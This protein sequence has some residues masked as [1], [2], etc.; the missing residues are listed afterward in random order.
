MPTRA[1][2][3]PRANGKPRLFAGVL[4]VYLNTPFHDLRVKY[5]QALAP[6]CQ[7]RCFGAMMSSEAILG[8]VV[9]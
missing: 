8:M 3:Q 2:L 1:A 4:Y 9:V 5:G 7:H 6:A